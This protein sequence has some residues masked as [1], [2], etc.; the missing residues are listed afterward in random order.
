MSWLQ[1]LFIHTIGQPSLLAVST[2]MMPSEKKSEA[3]ALS[4]TASSPSLATTSACSHKGFCLSQKRYSRQFLI[5][6]QCCLCQFTRSHKGCFVDHSNH[7][8]VFQN[9]L[10]SESFSTLGHNLTGGHKGFCVS[11]SRY[12]CP[13]QFFQRRCLYQFRRIQLATQFVNLG[14][15]KGLIM[16]LVSQDAA[17]LTES[18]CCLSLA[19]WAGFLVKNVSRAFVFVYVNLVCSIHSQIWSVPTSCVSSTAA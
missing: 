1:M 9:I 11:Q 2:I 12:N 6:Q 8:Y 7:N 19:I 5:F 15:K 4:E 14:P 18:I 3:A 13:F 10:L 17:K 16:M